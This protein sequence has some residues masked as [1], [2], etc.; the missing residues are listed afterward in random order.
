MWVGNGNRS[1][2]AS[3]QRYILSS[4]N[5]VSVKLESSELSADVLLRTP[6]HHYRARPKRKILR[7]SKPIDEF[8][9]ISPTNSVTSTDHSIDLVHEA[10]CCIAKGVRCGG[11]Q[12]VN[13]G[14]GVGAMG[15]SLAGLLYLR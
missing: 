1:S 4:T 11:P 7:A 10:N 5:P 2:R 8:L 12:W 9:P 14:H 6:N 3:A 13:L 15:P